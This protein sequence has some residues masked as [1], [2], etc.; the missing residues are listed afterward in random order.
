MTD[1][2]EAVESLPDEWQ[3]G[4]CNDKD[5]PPSNDAVNVVHYR[6]LLEKASSHD[7]SMD[8]GTSV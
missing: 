1:L 6:H 3:R 7:P 5:R 2:E 8:W 4:D